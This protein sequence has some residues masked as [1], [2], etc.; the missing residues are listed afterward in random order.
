MQYSRITSHT[1]FDNKYHLIWITKYR[2]KILKDAVGQRARDIIRQICEK[3]GVEIIRGHLSPDHVHLFVSIPPHYAVSKIIQNL[4]GRTS[5]ILQQEF[6]DL[7]RQYWGR[8]LWGIGF[9]CITSGNV[10]DEMIIQ[11]IEDQG[12]LRDDDLFQI[13]P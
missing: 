10:T 5:R 11:Y 4:K 12:K 8:H 9:F 7:R 13:T 2:K 1:K 6:P 3:F